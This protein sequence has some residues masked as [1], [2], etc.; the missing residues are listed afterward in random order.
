M[1]LFITFECLYMWVKVL[2]YV[3][4]E[5]FVSAKEGFCWH[6]LMTLSLSPMQWLGVQ[7]QLMLSVILDIS[8]KVCQ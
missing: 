1:Q 7:V 6:G 4:C 8:G 3:S 5:T 2:P